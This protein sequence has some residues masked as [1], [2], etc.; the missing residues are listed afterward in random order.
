MHVYIYT[1][2][3]IYVYIHIYMCIHISIYGISP[4]ICWWIILVSFYFELGFLYFVNFKLYFPSF[5]WTGILICQIDEIKNKQYQ[6]SLNIKKDETKSITSDDDNS[7][8]NSLDHKSDDYDYICN[9]HNDTVNDTNN[10]VNTSSMSNIKAGL[11]KNDILLSLN[12][13]DVAND[14]TISL[15]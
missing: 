11:R 15:R 4:Y 6:E 2:M 12:D 9:N 7:D 5:W 3:Y 10:N 14:A 8:N 13:L 1:H